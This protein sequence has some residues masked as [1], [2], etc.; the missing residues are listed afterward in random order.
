M[1]CESHISS[2]AKLK[3]EDLELLNNTGETL[4][5]LMPTNWPIKSL[6]QELIVEYQ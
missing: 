2:S 3:F 5:K 1:D 4:G 6:L